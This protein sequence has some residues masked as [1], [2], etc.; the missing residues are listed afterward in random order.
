MGLEAW[1]KKRLKHFVLNVSLSSKPGRL[2]AIVGPSG[3]GKTT[4]IRI[5]AGLERP[6]EGLITCGNK[7]WT[8]TRR[9]ISIPTRKRGIGYV[10]QEFS[11][12]PHLSVYRNVAFAAKDTS[13]VEDFLK[14]F[15][16]WHIRDSKPHL[17]SGGERQR[18]AICQALARTPKTLLMDEPFSALDALSRR[19][20]R[21]M[22]KSLKTELNIPIIHVTHDIREAL[23]LAD[24]ILPIVQGRV[25]GKWILQ[26][27]L[28]SRE[29]GRCLGSGIS[30]GNEDEEEIELSMLTKESLR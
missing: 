30:V 5:L 24:E 19:K 12:F 26:F 21:E 11:L 13:R 9:R 23:F 28:M 1:M 17:I 29:V 2:L 6:D 8:D 18:C 14:M 16:I 22:L 20:L 27:M 7:T 15:D 4:I 25:E 10:F 3:A